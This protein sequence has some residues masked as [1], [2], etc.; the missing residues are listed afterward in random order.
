MNQLEEIYTYTKTK[1]KS[2]V[3]QLVLPEVQGFVKRACPTAGRTRRGRAQVSGRL[4]WAFFVFFLFLFF[5]FFGLCLEM[6]VQKC[7][8]MSGLWWALVLWT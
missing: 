2:T 4:L 7:G 5:F 8:R 3:V 6:E 1:I